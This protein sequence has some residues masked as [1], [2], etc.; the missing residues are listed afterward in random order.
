MATI[1]KRGNSYR[2]MAS[3]GYDVDGTQEKRR[4]TWKPEP[5]MTERQIQKELQRQAVLFEEECRRGYVIQKSL[6]FEEFAKQYFEDYAD[7]NLRVRTAAEYHRMEKKTYKAIGHCKMDKITPLEVQKFIRSLVKGDTKTKAVS[8]KTAKNYLAFVSSVFTYAIQMRLVKENPCHAIKVALG[9]HE[10]RDCYTLE[11]AQQFLNLLAKESLFYQAFFTLAIYGGY[12]RG[13]L[14][15][16][17][18]KDIDFDTCVVSIRRT[19]LYTKAKGT[20][21]DTTKTKSSKRS[22][23]MP[24]EVIEIL[25]RYRVEQNTH[26][27]KVGDQWVSTDRLFT[28]WNGKPINPNSPYKW[29]CRFCERT[30]MRRAKSALHSFRHLNASLLI[31]NG[32]DVKTVST[33]LGHTQVSTTTNIYA[34]TFAKVQADA[35]EAI[36]K[37]LPLKSHA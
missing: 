18:W 8:P 25:L 24:A 20:F 2:I 1:E 10:E 15:G 4:M 23:K 37:A 7:Q 31:T 26:R 29:L 28:Y 36:A 32:V 3:C 13:E 27:L 12:R 6:K 5:G 9:E 16:L 19:S 22:L 34:H 30:G 33:A 11:E 21:T 35:S 17:E 14:C